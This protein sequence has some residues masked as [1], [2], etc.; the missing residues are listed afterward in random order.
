MPIDLICGQTLP[1]PYAKSA[2]SEKLADMDGTPTEAY[3]KLYEHFAR[4]P[5]I[6]LL[7]TGH[8]MITK[9]GRGEPN[10]I[11]IHPRDVAEMTETVHMMAKT[12]DAV[13]AI[14]PDVRLI[15]QINHC[16]RQVPKS[17]VKANFEGFSDSLYSERV[18]SF[19]DTAV[20]HTMGAF[21]KPLNIKYE[22]E[23]YTEGREAPIL[24]ELTREYA[25]AAD[26]LVNRCGLHGVQVHVSHGYLMNDIVS[27]GGWAVLERVLE[28]CRERIGSNK[29]L[30]VKI[31]IPTEDEDLQEYKRRLAGIIA[32]D[33]VKL[34]IVEFSGGSYSKPIMINNTTVPFS[35]AF[36]QDFKK[37]L[38]AEGSKCC[39]MPTGRFTSKE[40]ADKTIKETGVDLIGFGRAFCLPEPFAESTTRIVRAGLPLNKFSSKIMYSFGKLSPF[41]AA[42][43]NTVYFAS[44][45]PLIA[46]GTV[47]TN[48]EADAYGRK[49]CGLIWYL[50]LIFGMK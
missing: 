47:K 28:K 12:V 29:I 42:G 50:K 34:D 31:N 21:P 22:L 27:H 39:V 3:V 48:E 2:L 37:H 18:I 5:G 38:V 33:K 24:D 44:F 23:A 49:T 10:N 41:A 35:L 11:V 15:A 19:G 9:K 46:N 14:N 30:A 40:M 7:I 13:R 25:D 4:Q 45:F 36:S 16:G 17:L 43:P 6:G 32:S 20:E 26:C 1:T 8:I